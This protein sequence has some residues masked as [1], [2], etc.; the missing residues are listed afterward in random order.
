MPHNERLRLFLKH[1][2]GKTGTSPDLS[3][4]D[5]DFAHSMATAEM[6]D[7]MHFM[8]RE[9]MRRTATRMKREDD[10]Q[11]LEWNTYRMHSGNGFL[12]TTDEARVLFR[13]LGEVMGKEGGKMFGDNQADFAAAMSLY[14]KLGA[15][16]PSQ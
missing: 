7:E 14:V 2:C 11:R 6:L 12:L 10:R 13:M 8:M 16:M 3:Q 4:Q 5:Y 15:A 1:M 9:L